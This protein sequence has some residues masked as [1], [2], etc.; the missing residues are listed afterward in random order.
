MT[1]ISSNFTY[2]FEN[3]QQQKQEET[4][5]KEII[6]NC[7]NFIVN[8][9]TSKVKNKENENLSQRKTMFSS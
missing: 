1:G 9:F 7:V 3:H 2:I 4:T 5:F 6:N 8:L